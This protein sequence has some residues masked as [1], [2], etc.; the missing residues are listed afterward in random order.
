MSRDRYKHF[1]VSSDGEFLGAE[2]DWV[3]IIGGQM[4]GDTRNTALE[5]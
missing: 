5:I 3:I 4:D 1:I 2:N